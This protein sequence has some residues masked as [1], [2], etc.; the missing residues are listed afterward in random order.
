[1]FQ[2][3]LKFQKKPVAPLRSFPPSR[4]NEFVATDL[5]GPLS[6]TE[7]YKWILTMVCRFVKFVVAIPLRNA[8]SVEIPKAF[9]KFGV[10]E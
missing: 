1:M 7:Y 10:P 8:T 4:P 5:I 3:N 2:I 6:K 9:V